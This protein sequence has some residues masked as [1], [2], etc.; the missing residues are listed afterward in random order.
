[1][2]IGMKRFYIEL[3]MEE[4]GCTAIRPAVIEGM[5]VQGGT[6]E[7]GAFDNPAREA[8]LFSAPAEIASRHSGMYTD[9][10]GGYA[11]VEGP[12]RLLTPEEYE[13]LIREV[14]NRTAQSEKSGE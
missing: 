2:S 3:P 5:I 7:A 12:A 8:L 14:K 4:D 10:F 1:M 6:P 13:A 11:E 9:A